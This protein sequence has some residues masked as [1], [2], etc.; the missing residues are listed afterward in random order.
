MG[1]HH[2]D[3][4]LRNVA[5]PPVGS[6]ILIFGAGAVGLAALLAAQ[7]TAPASLVLV[8]HS[9]AKLDSIPKEILVDVQVFNFSGMRREETVGILRRFS[10]DGKGMDFALDCAGS[11]EVIATCA[12]SLSKCG[13][14]LTVGGVLPGQETSFMSEKFLV[15]G[16]TYRGT[17]QGDSVPRIMIPEMIRQWRQGRFPFDKLLNRFKFEELE[18]ALEA[19]KAGRIIKPL[20]VVQ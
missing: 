14:V 6:S 12:E 17:H 5:R 2:I 20:L 11:P 10:V 4:G 18:N 13:T 1:C 7:L 8:E 15:G 9:Q 16:L 3:A 19:A